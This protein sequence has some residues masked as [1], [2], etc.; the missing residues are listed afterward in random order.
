MSENTVEQKLTLKDR[1]KYFFI[2]P[3]IL[4]ERFIDKPK[5][6]INLL[7]LILSSVLYSVISSKFSK[8]L[9]K[10]LM[11]S[12]TKGL[13]PQQAEA[14]KKIAEFTTSPIFGS[15]SAILGIII[16]VF[17]TSLILFLILKVSKISLKYKQIVSIYTLASITT[18]I[19]NVIQSIYVLISQKPIGTIKTVTSVIS[20]SINVFSI[21]K[22]VLI[23]IGI[24][25]VSKT[26]KKKAAIITIICFI[27]FSAIL[28][29]SGLSAVK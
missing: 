11:E 12:Q 27:L 2:N 17:F 23:G 8:D 28:I 10:N 19:Y 13:T 14:T 3:K 4:F 15:I 21:W 25:A 9:M 16:G 6:G 26:S 29:A 1:I 22:Y 7:I 18:V 5:Y 24:Y 20:S